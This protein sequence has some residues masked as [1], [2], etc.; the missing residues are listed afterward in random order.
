MRKKLSN[1]ELQ[2]LHLVADEMTSKQIAVK[3]GISKRTVD[4][5]RYQIGKKLGITGTHSL[6]KYALLNREKLSELM[7]KSKDLFDLHVT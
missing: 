5:H 2:V 4:R 6:I 7:I 1:R 3:L